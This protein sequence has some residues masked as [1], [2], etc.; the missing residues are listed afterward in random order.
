MQNNAA[1]LSSDAPEVLTLLTQMPDLPPYIYGRECGENEKVWSSAAVQEVR[2]QALAFALALQPELRERV[3]QSWQY[4]FFFQ[5]GNASA[6]LLKDEN[7]DAF[8]KEY[9]RLLGLWAAAVDLLDNQ[10]ARRAAIEQKKGAGEERLTPWHFEEQ[11]ANPEAVD[12]AMAWPVWFRFEQEPSPQTI[13]ELKR[14][15][16]AAF[17]GLSIALETPARYLCAES[18]ITVHV[19]EAHRH[20]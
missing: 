7:G 9:E 18:V 12:G 14:L 4:T 5:L 19:V 11:E 20:V 17:N 15:C 16:E 6:D 3:P 13:E 2:R 8:D 1:V 10:L